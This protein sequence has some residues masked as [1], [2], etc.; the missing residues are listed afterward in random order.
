MK[1][2]QLPSSLHISTRAVAHH[3]NFGDA[4]GI[5]IVFIILTVIYTTKY[6]G[7]HQTG[8]F[9]VILNWKKAQKMR[10]NLEKIDGGCGWI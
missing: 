6:Y 7:S 9:R 2:G 3:P 4:G 10:E 5:Y 1:S 8:F